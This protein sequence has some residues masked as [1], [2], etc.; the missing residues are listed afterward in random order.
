MRGM[1]TKGYVWHFTSYL[2]SLC[3]ISFPEPAFLR[4]PRGHAGLRNEI[5][6][7]CEY[8]WSA[9]QSQ[10]PDPTKYA[11]G[12][13]QSQRFH[14]IAG[15]H[16]SYKITCMWNAMNELTPS[17]PKKKNTLKKPNYNFLSL[18]NFTDSSSH[19]R[20]SVTLH[21]LSRDRGHMTIVILMV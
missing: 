21:H 4:R 2:W 8:Y 12:G 7:S 19:V 6:L 9:F 15:K 13:R 3:S 5:G 1:R 11:F 14:Y 17:P 20:S 18:L 16:K 10:T